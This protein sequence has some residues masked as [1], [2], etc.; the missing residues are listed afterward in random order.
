MF[1]KERS[2]VLNVT[3]KIKIEKTTQFDNVEV[4]DD[5]EKGISGMGWRENVKCGK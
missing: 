5:F 2:I 4:N 3:C 1:Q